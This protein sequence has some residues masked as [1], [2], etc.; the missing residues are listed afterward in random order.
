MNRREFLITPIA[1]VP[2]AAVSTEAAMS[3]LSQN[4]VDLSGRD[5]IFYD[6]VA[7]V[8]AA[9]L[10]VYVNIPLGPPGTI[11]GSSDRS[12]QVYRRVI[13]Y[14]IK[15][16]PAKDTDILEWLNATMSY[17]EQVIDDAVKYIVRETHNVEHPEILMWPGS[18]IV[19][20][21]FDYTNYCTSYIAVAVT[22]G[23]VT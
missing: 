14:S 12:C 23:V 5:K 8:R 19:E 17:R 10:K 3:A 15:P 13:A 1:L 4:P 6:I 11:F 21:D 2:F 18:I 22:F 7:K 20:Q 9:G 16:I